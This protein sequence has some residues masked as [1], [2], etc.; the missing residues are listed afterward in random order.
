MRTILVAVLHEFGKQ[1]LKM[2][3]IHDDEVVKALAAQSPDHSL[4]DGVA[5]WRVDWSGDGVDAGA[6][7]A[8]EVAAIDRIAISE[9]VAWSVAPGRGLDDLPPHPG[10]RRAGRH[11][12][13]HQLAPTMGDEHHH[14]QRLERQGGAGQQIGGPEMVSM[15]AQER[16]PAL[17]W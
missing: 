1:R 4:R 9:Q 16:A 10:C 12:D 17:R 15:V 2:L 11:I 3:L 7:G 6:L 5:L 8:A 13:M 14:V